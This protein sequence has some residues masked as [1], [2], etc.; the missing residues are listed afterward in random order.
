MVLY[1]ELVEAVAVVEL[2]EQERQ[3]VLAQ[4]AM[5]AMDLK[6]RLMLLLMVVL[7]PEVHHLQDTF[8][9]AVVVVLMAAHP[10]QVVMVAVVQQVLQVATIPE[11]QEQ[12]L[13][14]EVAEQGF[15]VPANLLEAQAAPVSSS[16]STPLLAKRSSY[17]KALQRGNARQV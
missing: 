7:V 1:L 5:V 12:P 17:S 11:L 15:I 8:L 6:A 3:P 9:V 2:A 4:Q 13:A 10:E 16:S 14:V